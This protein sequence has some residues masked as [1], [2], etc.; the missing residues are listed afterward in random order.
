MEA[1]S[2]LDMDGHREQEWWRGRGLVCMIGH[3]KRDKCAHDSHSLSDVAAAQHKTSVSAR[4]GG[5]GAQFYAASGCCCDAYNTDGWLNCTI[6]AQSYAADSIIACARA[7]VGRHAAHHFR[8][9]QLAVRR[10][11][12]LLEV[13]W[14]D[15]GSVSDATRAGGRGAG[16]ARGDEDARRYRLSAS[17]RRRSEAAL[18]VA[19]TLRW[20]WRLARLNTMR[21]ARS[22]WPTAHY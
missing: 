15:V 10:Q 6:E 2:Q 12:R 16:E 9:Q 3:E 17:T 8:R 19:P 7:S 18:G 20:R 21:W 22:M 14:P 11:E 5:G 13:Q 1:V 4:G